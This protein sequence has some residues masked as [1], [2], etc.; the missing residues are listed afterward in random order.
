VRKVDASALA[1]QAG[2]V[3][4]ANVV[5]LGAMASALPFTPEMLE[6]VIRKSVP[7]KAVDVNLTAFNLGLEVAVPA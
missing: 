4:A 3:K 6:S 5:M 7:P 1:A 2:T